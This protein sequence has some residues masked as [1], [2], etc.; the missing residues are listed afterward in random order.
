VLLKALEL[1]GF[2]SFPDKLRVEFPGG[3]TAI[4]GPN[5]S[6]KS[7]IA[8]AIRWVLGE[9]STKTLRGSKMEDVIFAGA[10]GRRPTGFAEVSLT[11][12]NSTGILKTDYAEVEVTR[13]YD[14]SGESEYFLNR[15]SVRLR[16]IHELFMDTGL[17]R[18]GYSV[19]G[20]G[21]IDEILSVRAQ[22]RREI[23]DEAAGITKYRWRREEAERKLAAAEENLLRVGDL[24]TELES[25]LVPMGRQA[26]KERKYNALREQLRGIE[27]G[28]WLCQ[29]QQAA[30]DR[31]VAQAEYVQAQAGA[32]DCR[33]AVEAIYAAAEALSLKARDLEQEQEQLRAALQADTATLSAVDSEI[34]LRR[35]AIER[36]LAD[37]TRLE[38]ESDDYRLRCEQLQRQLE[39][40]DGRLKQYETEQTDADTR[41]R[42]AEQAVQAAQQAVDV[43]VAQD[44]ALQHQMEELA[45]IRHRSE[46]AASAAGSTAQE[47]RARLDGAGTEESE[48][49]RA[50]EEARKAA[51]ALREEVRKGADDLSSMGNVMAGYERLRAARAGRE[52]EARDRHTRLRIRL[53][54]IDNRIRLLRELER[55]YEGYNKAVRAVLTRREQLGGI[56]GPVSELIRTADE[57]V[58]AVETAL[59]ASLQQ[60]VV[61]REEDARRAIGM[62]KSRGEG[63]A[64]FLPLSAVH[65]TELAGREIENLP[66]FVGV[67]SRLVEYDPLYTQI[68]RNL[69]GRTIVI[70]HID[71]AI[72][73]ARRTGHRYRLVTLDG[74]VLSPGGAMTGGS[75][76][77][78]A[79]ILSRANELTRLEQERVQAQ[80]AFEQA[81]SALDRAVQDNAALRYQLDNA[82]VQ[83]QEAQNVQTRREAAFERQEAL[84]ASLEAELTGGDS[85]KVSL[86]NRLDALLD[87]VRQEEREQQTLDEQRR[88]LEEQQIQLQQRYDLALAEKTGRERALNALR[89][90]TLRREG[91]RSAA[92][93]EQ[94][95]LQAHLESVR[96]D[97]TYRDN[98]MEDFETENARLESEISEKETQREEYLQTQQR[99][100]EKL[101]DT[102][103]RRAELEAARVRDDKRLQETNQ[104][105]LKFERDCVRLEDRVESLTAREDKL[106]TRLWEE[107]NLTREAA[108]EEAVIPQETDAASEQ[109]ESLRR[110]IRD[111]GS[112]Y[113]GAIEEYE[114]LKERY[115]FLNA[116]REDA[117]N[118]REQLT[119]VI[120]ELQKQMRVQFTEQ[121]ALI[122]EQF[123]SIF[124]EIFGGGTGCIE[125]EDTTDVLESGIEIRVQLPGKTMKVL[126]L[127]S[128]G[129]RALV[130]IALYFA[131]LRIRPSPFCILDE[132]DAALDDI[133]VSRFARYL[134]RFGDNT[135]FIVITHRRGTMESADMLYGVAMPVQG[136]SRLLAFDV[137]EAAEKLGLESNT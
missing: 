73:A 121:F 79:G 94:R 131:I 111:L 80:T 66:G 86:Q 95:Q 114:R 100:Q 35:A 135:Q 76:V 27:I 82:A 7:N 5:G 104:R 1:Q 136:V 137:R 103:T 51:E 19:I 112:V 129:E 108:S 120:D 55:E 107:Y 78:S 122:N 102:L 49:R 58:A 83:R 81:Q 61:E 77:V 126:S 12:D 113:T 93:A 22:D 3:I 42:D 38:R 13:R 96:Q 110:A 87:T 25:Q 57:Y 116:Q 132:I 46:L 88:E 98:R 62:L 14:R 89:Q 125:L 54:D 118:S 124:A 26:E 106:V 10:R 16:D 23:F 75:R 69:L 37:R 84:C 39:Q 64:T 115:E 28:L 123:G 29:L 134:R 133:N 8:D 47:L 36:N 41:I 63:R 9:Q 60:I 68:I 105:Q 24:V 53:A 50:L 21:R 56:H 31:A 40:L 34:A 92:V 90:E 45:Q 101:R 71:H 20:Q 119:G 11:L 30:A 99:H 70:D 17:G 15:K 52:E 130:A 32:E 6:G 85:L 43:L 2:K 48:R 59:G 33:R 18:D 44:D 109:A 65:G 128:G 127:L 91:E 72:E 67:M 4:V 117:Q 97:R 74:Q